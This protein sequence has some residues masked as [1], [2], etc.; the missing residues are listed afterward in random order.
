MIFSFVF[1]FSAAASRPAGRSIIQITGLP[2]SVKVG[3]AVGRSVER[4]Q[5]ADKM[6]HSTTA[7]ILRKKETSERN[8]VPVAQ[9]QLAAAA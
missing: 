8:V 1:N 5:L 9:W 4:M 7:S 2:Q 6:G 3:I